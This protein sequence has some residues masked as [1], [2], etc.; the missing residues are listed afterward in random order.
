MKIRWLWIVIAT[1]LVAWTGRADAFCGFYVAGTESTLTN[2]ATLVVMMRDG[3][4]TV[5]SMQNT[6]AGPPQDF[7]LVVPVPVVLREANVKILPRD[8]FTKVEQLTAPRLVEYWEQDPCSPP[9]MYEMA[10]AAAASGAA[11]KEEEEKSATKNRVKIE[12]RFAVGEYDVVVLSAQDSTG[13]DSWLHE[14]NYKIPA[15]AEPYLRPYVQMGMKF[16]VAKVNVAKV[17]FERVGNGPEHAVL[18]P[19]RFHYDAD[20]FFLPVRLG[21]INSSGKQ[22]LVV[23]ILARNQRYEVANYDNVAI[24]TNLDVADGVRRQFAAFYASLFDRVVAKNPRAVVTEY[25]WD[26]SSCDPCPIPPLEDQDLATLGADVLP[27]TDPNQGYYGGGFTVTRLHAR[28]GRDTLGDDLHFR[29]APAIVGGRESSGPDGKI[30][31]GARPDSTNNFQA[32]YIIRH[33]WAGA[34]ACE[35]PNFGIW[36]GPPDGRQPEPVPAVNLAF[37]ARDADLGAL[38]KSPLPEGLTLSRGEVVGPPRIPPGEGGCA[39]CSTAPSGG[40]Y[41]A[42]GACAFVFVAMVRRSRRRR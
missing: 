2:D 22:D 8:V 15:G 1:V 3:T 40:D 31:Q 33:K 42:A 5:L 18:S 36:G 9:V 6:Y 27:T 4:R 41:A 23:V 20:D 21:L 38:V 32:R 16:F 17:K 12:A 34:V 29:P 26:A 24:P 25:S 30:E 14:N 19:L 10:P 39:G 13:L 35:H 7:A 37:A 11:D 28:Y